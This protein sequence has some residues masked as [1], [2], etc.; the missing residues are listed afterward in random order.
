MRSSVV[1]I[2]FCIGKKRFIIPISWFGCCRLEYI[3]VRIVCNA[4]HIDRWLPINYYGYWILLWMVM[5]AVPFHGNCTFCSPQFWCVLDG[6]MFKIFSCNL[7]FNRNNDWATGD[8][9][10]AQICVAMD[11]KTDTQF[12]LWWL[13]STINLWN[14][15]LCTILIN[16]RNR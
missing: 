2:Q 8:R 4:P 7:K 12:I 16:V 14:D 10:P 3:Y 6:S 13:K 11:I 5:C 1:H 15:V 9:C